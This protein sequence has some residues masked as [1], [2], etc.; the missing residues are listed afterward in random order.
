MAESPPERPVCGLSSSEEEPSGA[1]SSQL[2]GQGVQLPVA[3]P[4]QASSNPDETWFEEPR[5]YEA[6]L[7]I[8]DPENSRIVPHVVST[9]MTVAAVDRI[10]AYCRSLN[11]PEPIMRWTDVER[12]LAPPREPVGWLAK[13]LG[14][15]TVRGRA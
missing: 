12:E 10:N 5:E 14:R 3:V 11:L 15:L 13:H 8:L 1:E 9:A 2:M 4:G 6:S 7:T